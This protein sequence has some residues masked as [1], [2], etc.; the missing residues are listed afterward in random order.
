MNKVPKLSVIVPV[1]NVEE[2][3]ERCLD[4]LT[5]QTYSNLEVLLID[6]GATDSSGQICD[7]Y[8][9]SY[10]KVRVF[11]VENGGV[12]A[13]RNLGIKESTG[14]YI[15]F[16]DSDDW[17][18]L[19]AY[20]RLMKPIAEKNVDIAAFGWVVDN[21]S[22]YQS[23][24]TENAYCGYGGEADFFKLILSKS[25]NFGGK[26]GYGNYIWNKIY[27]RSILNDKNGN[28]I[29]FDKEVKIAEDGLWLVNIAQN[30][31][32]SYFD[33]SAFYHYFINRKSVM[34]DNT[35][36][37]ETRLGSEKSHI[38]MLDILKAYNTE[39]YEIHR[40]TCLDYFW[41]ITKSSPM[42]IS[43]E[44]IRDSINNI[45]YINNGQ[46]TDEMAKDIH[47]YMRMNLRYK[48]LL[49]KKPV[50]ILRKCRNFVYSIKRRVKSLWTKKTDEPMMEEFAEEME[51]E[52]R[53][54]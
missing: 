38:V 41:A 6:D 49:N 40:Q 11:H 5:K 15:T 46:L 3:L 44:F 27:K 26:T 31:K 16:C 10:E 12:S 9:A 8:A 35:R 42:L 36:F 18:E 4:S 13:A 20:E 51:E 48:R 25:G 14:E 34:R 29:P 53:S 7:R 52:T 45:L 17:L 32:V 21:A 37:M 30:C 33:S 19:D 54:E 1:Y 43:A 24:E 50:R 39:Y 2:F 22:N 23:D 28:L 47:Y